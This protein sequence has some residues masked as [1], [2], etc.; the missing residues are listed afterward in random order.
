MIFDNEYYNKTI[1]Q[2]NYNPMDFAPMDFEFNKISPEIM[3]SKW[4]CHSGIN[5]ITD[6]SQCII[7]SGIGLS[8]V[9]HMGT[10]SQILRLIFLQKAGFA[11]QM[12]LGDL[13]SY[14]ARNV[15]LD[16]VRER[17][18]LYN[19]FIVELGFDA[20]KGIL[21]SQ[22]EETDV[23]RMAF[24]AAKY[25]TDK[26]FEETEEDLSEL[27]KKEK[28]YEGITFPVKQSILLMVA[29][30]LHLGSKK[31]YKDVVVMLGLE[32]HQYVLLARKA[33]ERMKMNFNIYG[34]YS[35]IIKGLNGY[36]KMSKSILASSIRVDMSKD[37]IMNAIVNEKD[38]Y[39]KPDDSVIYQLMSNVSLYSL[40]ELKKIYIECE[41]RSKEW[42]DIK[43]SYGDMLADICKKWQ[44]I[45]SKE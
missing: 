34:M 5:N 39:G 3:D 11:V 20:K 7:T 28:I 24:L 32:E 21:R 30:F 17:A 13:D 10:L 36:P 6:Y 33:L 31:N 2:Y 1:K 44:I 35:R 15:E 22:Y 4:L 43:I 25:L 37:E 45:A 26:D 42:D 27:Y 18:K 29:D 40:E 16:L 41:S 38:Q 19:E 23:L 14:N 12:V 9:P 8:G